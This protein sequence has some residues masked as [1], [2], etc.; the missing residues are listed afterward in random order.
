MDFDF[1]KFV[2]ELD[3]SLLAN[4]LNNIII[5]KFASLQNEAKTME[6][7]EIFAISNLF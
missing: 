1:P 4:E 2:S 3:T 6:N 5:A 7:I